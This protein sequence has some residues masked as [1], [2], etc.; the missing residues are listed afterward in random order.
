M[1]EITRILQ[2]LEVG[3]PQST[4]RL[5]SLVYDELRGLAAQ[6]I[7][8]ENPGNT[9]Q[10]TAL[11]N[12]VFLRLVGESSRESAWQNRRHFF[13]AAAEAMRRI[14]VDAARKRAAQKRGG[15]FDRSDFDVTQIPAPTN[16]QEVLSINEAMDQLAVADPDAAE[17]VKL[18]FFAGMT[19]Q[20]IADIQGISIRKAQDVWAYARS[21]L[22]TE[23]SNPK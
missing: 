11:V 23:L 6:K 12:E 19:M 16:D 7:R 8:T 2:S 5:L 20:E 3:Q 14:L 4:E 22:R 17:L 13:G 21:W 9:L 15:K 1:S 18:R 10:A